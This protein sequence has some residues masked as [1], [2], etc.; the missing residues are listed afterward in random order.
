MDPGFNQ[1]LIQFLSM[2]FAIGVQEILKEDSRAQ[3]PSHARAREIA[4][5]VLRANGDHDPLGRK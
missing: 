3:P 5:R 4:A 1:E 2:R